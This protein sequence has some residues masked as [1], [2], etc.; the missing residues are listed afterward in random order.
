MLGANSELT[1]TV[2]IC[3]VLHLSILIFFSE[4][5]LHVQGQM[6]D[7]DQGGQLSNFNSL[8]GLNSL[9]NRVLNKNKNNLII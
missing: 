2:L 4:I 6:Q 7:F 9:T 8:S 1:I 5:H 3:N